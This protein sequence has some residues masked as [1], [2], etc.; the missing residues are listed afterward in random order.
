[1]CREPLKP[2]SE[3]EPLAIR[4]KT[5][6]ITI[7]SYQ[8]TD[9][10]WVPKALVTPSPENEERGQLVVDEVEHPLIT[11]ETADRVAKKKAIEWIDAAQYP[12]ATN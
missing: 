6:D 5:C 10:R 7:L 1:M 12:L 8:L 9:G 11:R 4:H 3:G 2:K